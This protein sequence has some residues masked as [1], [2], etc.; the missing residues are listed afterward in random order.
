MVA[1]GLPISLKGI[2]DDARVGSRKSK[3]LP[4]P[5]EIV[6]AWPTACKPSTPLPALQADPGLNDAVSIELGAPQGAPGRLGRSSARAKCF[7]RVFVA[8]SPNVED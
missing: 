1:A 7:G 3:E 8:S 5:R 4:A 2:G 6:A